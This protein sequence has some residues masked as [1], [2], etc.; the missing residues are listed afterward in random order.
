MRRVFDAISQL[1][2]IPASSAAEQRFLVREID[3]DQLPAHQV[4]EIEQ[5]YLRSRDKDEEI[6]IR[7]RGKEDSHLY[8]LRRTT[9][10]TFA[11]ASEELIDEQQYLN[12]GKLMDPK[13]EPLLKDRLC[14]L[15]NNRH[16]E[17]D[18]YHGRNE[19]LS[20]LAV[21][22]P[23]SEEGEPQIP[24]FISVSRNITGNGRY[25]ERRLAGK[26]KAEVPPGDG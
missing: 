10:G 1:L 4:V 24:P 19:G 13:T 15:W 20:V 16:F 8:F 12:L 5:I 9:K 21:E 17:V 2:G 3:H 6:D 26:R 7:K 23:D 25:T 18:R 22:P 14:F 11:V